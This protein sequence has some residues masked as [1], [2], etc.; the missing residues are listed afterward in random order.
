M[1]FQCSYSL[2]IESDRGELLADGRWTGLIG[3][4]KSKELDLIIGPIEPESRLLDFA[5]LSTPYDSLGSSIL[6]S[7]T[8]RVVRGSFA[9]FGWATALP[10][11]FWF[12][13]ILSSSIVALATLVIV[14]LRCIRQGQKTN[15]RLLGYIWLTVL[16]AILQPR[17]LNLS[18]IPKI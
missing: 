3:K 16:Y 14:Q 5:T 7:D 6:I 8:E 11:I 18:E 17:E 15:P 1:H 9:L 2:V 12:L 4:L 13:Y 10:F